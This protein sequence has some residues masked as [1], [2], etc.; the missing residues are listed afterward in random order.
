MGG[1]ERTIEEDVGD[2]EAGTE[3]D[4]GDEEIDVV[5][6]LD[7]GISGYESAGFT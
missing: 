7:V 4:V 3:A 6:V 2:T 1:V 5:G